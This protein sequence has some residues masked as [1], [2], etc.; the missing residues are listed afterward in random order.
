MTTLN[1]K[2]I[3]HLAVSAIAHKEGDF[4]LGYNSEKGEHVV[5]W[6]EKALGKIPDMAAL[7][8]AHA[9]HAITIKAAEERAKRD[10]LLAATDWTQGADIP[11]TIKSAHKPYR[12]ALRDVP[13][14]E[15]FPYNIIWPTKPE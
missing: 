1:D 3:A 5:H 4:H 12:Q 11:T 7:D 6:D 10:Q 8:A 15:G 13:L 9:A 2:I 14:Q